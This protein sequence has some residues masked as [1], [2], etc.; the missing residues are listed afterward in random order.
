MKDLSKD[1]EVAILN[2]IEVMGFAVDVTEVKSEKLASLMK[3]KIDSFTYT[4][5]LIVSWQNSQN[6]PSDFKLK[7]YV[8]KLIK[9]GEN[10]IETLRQAL[11]KNI[12]AEEVDAE[13]LGEAIKAKPII[14]KAIAE[15]NSGVIQL[16]TQ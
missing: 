13:K 2:A 11:R 5:E 14:F 8:E 1:L 9:S 10:S 4:K 15:I 16:R 7:G 12:D 3:S 6:S